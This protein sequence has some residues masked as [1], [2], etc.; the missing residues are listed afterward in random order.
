ML[1]ANKITKITIGGYEAFVH[2]AIIKKYLSSSDDRVYTVEGV[3]CSRTAVDIIVTEL[4]EGLPGVNIHNYMTRNAS[5]GKIGD[6]L[7]YD[8]SSDDIIF[9]AEFYDKYVET[10]YLDYMVDNYSISKHVKN[11]VVE[12]ITTDTQNCDVIVGSDYFE[13]RDGKTNII[14]DGIIRDSIIDGF[15]KEKNV[16]PSVFKLLFF[17]HGASDLSS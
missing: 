3:Q 4:Y 9:I 15:C 8:C 12:H 13:I 16:H 5:P 6:I 7:S 2:D 14:L 1:E 11:Y 17:A 10:L